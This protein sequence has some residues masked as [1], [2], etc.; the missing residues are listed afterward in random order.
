[1][2]TH[3]GQFRH[4]S[5]FS[6]W[7]FQ[8]GRNLAI[9]HL[10]RRD[11]RPRTVSGPLPDRGDPASPHRM[12]EISS[13]L[14]ALDHRQREALLLVEIVGLTYV[15]VGIVLGVPPGTVK[16]RVHHARHALRARLADDEGLSGAL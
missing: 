5:K 8:V 13:A 11:R 15:E 16:S 9:D 4:E 6:T 10:R 1:M 3:L 7:L 14:A 12:L 2:F